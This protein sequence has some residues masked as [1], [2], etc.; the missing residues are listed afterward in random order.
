M[1]I[2]V[3]TV[4]YNAV[5]RIER[6]VRSV[7]TQT[8]CDFEYIIIDGGSQDGTVDIISTYEEKISFWSSESDSGIYN[9]MN[10]GTRVAKGDFCLFLNAGDMLFGPD[11]LERVAGFLTPEYS[12]V[13]GNQVFLSPSGKIVAYGKAW[14]EVTR[15]RLYS[16]SLYHQASFI[17]R[18]DLLEYPYDETLKMVSDW[19]AAYKLLI[20]EGGKYRGIDVNVDYFVEDGVT[21]TRQTEGR[22]EKRVLLDEYYSKEESEALERKLVEYKNVTNVSRYLNFLSRKLR[23]L[24]LKISLTVPAL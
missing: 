4:C 9:A 1:K 14:S 23:L 7:I 3:I 24:F 20:L 6:T 18:R 5:D 11:V 10:K 2:S 22:D 15:E 21:F 17:R 16:D 19:K 12:I 8:Y 13:M